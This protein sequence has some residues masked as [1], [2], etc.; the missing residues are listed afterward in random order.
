[1]IEQPVV[2]EAELARL[3]SCLTPPSVKRLFTVKDEGFYDVFY[4]LGIPTPFDEKRYPNISF[5]IAAEYTFQGL[6]N[7][8]TGGW[9]AIYYSNIWVCPTENGSDSGWSVEK[10]H[11]YDRFYGELN[12]ML[13]VAEETAADVPD[14]EQ[15]S[16]LRIDV[17]D[18]RLV[19]DTKYWRIRR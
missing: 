1:M 13:K 2:M 12:R 15:V 18:Q 5:E 8:L 10:F 6:K 9:V 17:S 19:E 11:R 7:L 16:L 14:L 3:I 4:F